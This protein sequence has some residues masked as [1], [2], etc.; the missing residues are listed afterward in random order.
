MTNKNSDDINIFRG[1]FIKIYKFNIYIKDKL[2]IDKILNNLKYCTSYNF[3][4]Y[5]KKYKNYYVK[6][7]YNCTKD[8]ITKYLIKKNKKIDIY[9]NKLVNNKLLLFEFILPNFLLYLKY[10]EK[11]QININDSLL[12]EKIKLKL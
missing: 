10:K 8:T 6:N 12:F 11:Y 1:C 4:K 7:S 2:L 3:E 5:Y 9:L